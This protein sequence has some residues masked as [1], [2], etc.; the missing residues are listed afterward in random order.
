MTT[1]LHANWGDEAKASQKILKAKRTKDP[2]R[3]HLLTFTIG[4]LLVCPF[5]FA[6]RIVSRGR[7]AYPR[8][9]GSSFVDE[10]S[11]VVSTALG[12]SLM[13]R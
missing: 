3:E 13:G 12:F 5:V 10:T 4:F 1:E 6:A 11:A 7:S 2:K 9:K 8:T